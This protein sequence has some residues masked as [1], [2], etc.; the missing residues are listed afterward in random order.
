VRTG[1]GGLLATQDRDNHHAMFAL[2]RHKLGRSSVPEDLSDLGN[3]QI[4]CKAVS[5]SIRG[6][7]E[8]MVC[9]SGRQRRMAKESLWICALDAS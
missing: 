1:T 4:V 3:H 6:Q 7:K 2:S 9:D 8:L 5:L